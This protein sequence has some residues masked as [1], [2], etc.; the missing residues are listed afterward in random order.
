M[1]EFIAS[2]LAM[3]LNKSTEEIAELLYTK[4]DEGEETLKDGS[5]DVVLGL[6]ESKIQGIKDESKAKQKEIADNFHK[7]GLKEASDKF[8]SELKEKYG[9]ESEEQGIELV[10]QL[11][12]KFKADDSKFTPDKVKIHPTYIEREKQLKK[13]AADLVKAKDAEIEELKA[14][15]VKT[16]AWSKVEKSIRSILMEKKP[17]L[18]KNQRAADNIVNMFLDSFSDY[19]WQVDD[20]GEHMAMKDGTRVEDKMGNALQFRSLVESRITDFFDLHVQ[21]DKGSAGNEGGDSTH[22]D[23]PTKFES[24]DA[25]SKYLDSTTDPEKREQAYKNYKAFPP[26]Q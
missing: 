25:Y 4:T 23:V 2:F 13:E 14:G 19:D 8:E 18:P 12:N 6:Y 20:N 24:E 17:V 9:L 11:V 16:Q 15:F 3:T 22:T 26:G 1:N 5:L 7:K 21:D 10:D